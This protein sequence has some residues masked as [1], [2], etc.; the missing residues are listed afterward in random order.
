[1]E[2]VWMKDNGQWGQQLSDSAWTPLTTIAAP[3]STTASSE[4]PSQAAQFYRVAQ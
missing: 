4:K 3:G 1:M 2:A